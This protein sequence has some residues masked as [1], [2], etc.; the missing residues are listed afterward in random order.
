[1]AESGFEGVNP[2]YFFCARIGDEVFMRF[3]PRG[4]GAMEPEDD[5]IV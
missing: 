4:W 3:V 2:G 1:V 5:V